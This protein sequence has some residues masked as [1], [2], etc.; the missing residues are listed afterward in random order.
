[1]ISKIGWIDFSPLHRERVKSFIELMEE[2]GVQ[3]ELGVGTIRDA[4]SNKLFPGFSTL[5]TSHPRQIF[6]YYTLHPTRQRA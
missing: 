1:M 3:D 2:G 6:L 5:H 4:M